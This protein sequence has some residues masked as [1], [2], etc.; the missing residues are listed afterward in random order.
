[1]TNRVGKSDAEALMNDLMP[2]ATQMLTAYR[3]FA[4]FGGYMKC[5]G[6]IVWEG[7]RTELERTPSR[8]SIEILL[9]A[10]RRLARDRRIRACATVYDVRTVPPGRT[11]ECDAIAVA[12]DHESGYSVVVVHPYRF[13]ASGDLEF[14]APFANRG[15]CSVFGEEPA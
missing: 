8:T 14:A 7:A 3:E 2:F 12:L 15:T 4:P 11:E 1:M 10:H 13:D 6:E 9:D 5:D